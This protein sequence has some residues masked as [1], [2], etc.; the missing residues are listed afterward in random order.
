VRSRYR[1]FG[2]QLGRR[3]PGAIVP[4]GR[5]VSE[6]ASALA[7]HSGCRSRSLPD[8]IIPATAILHGAKLATLN[9]ADFERFATDGLELA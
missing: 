1:R 2:T 4:S 3:T 9:R 6:R 7:N 5:R 8:C